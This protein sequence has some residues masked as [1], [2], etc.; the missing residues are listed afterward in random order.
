M[1]NFDIFLAAYVEA[2][3][4]SSSG[5]DQHGAGFWDR[6]L[7]DLGDRLTMLAQ[8]YEESDPYVGDDG[9]IYY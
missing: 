3:L 1:S 9:K 5:T 4:W 8:T 7:G 6:G 2:M